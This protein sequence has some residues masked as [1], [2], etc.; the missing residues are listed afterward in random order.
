MI[1]LI[2]LMRILYIFHK[3]NILGD[4]KSLGLLG[5]VSS[6]INFYKSKKHSTGYRLALALEELGPIFI[7]IGQTLSIR[8]DIIGKEIADELVKLQNNLKSSDFSLIKK[9]IEAEFQDSLENIFTDF[10]Q[11][12]V[13]AASIA[14]VHKAVINDKIVAVKILRPDIEK[15]FLKDIK[16]MYF[17]AR[18]MEY[19]ISNSSRLKATDI[20]KNFHQNILIELDLTLEAAAANTIQDY[21]KDDDTIIVPEIYWEYT[22]K[23][24]L[25]M[26]WVDGTSIYNEQELALLEIDNIEVATNLA[27]MFFLQAFNHGFYHA[28]L[29]PG[30]ILISNT[31]K[32]I[33]LDFGIMGRLEQSLRISMAEIIYGFLKKDYDL[34]AEIYFREGFVPRTKSK[35]L[36]SQSL[37]AI[38]EP[39]VGKPVSE[40]SI[41]RLIGKLLEMSQRFEMVTK[42]ELFALQKT[43]TLIEGI[44][45]KLDPKINMWQLARPW[46]NEWAIKNI[47]I[48]GKMKNLFQNILKKISNNLQDLN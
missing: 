13:A 5:K 33:L 34:V 21:H 44:G 1:N 32:I 40:I 30:N 29:H 43:M 24:I 36:L 42:P 41:A 2:R 39:I 23:N 11:Q 27:K 7:K 25:T 46:I 3:F 28:D 14:Q 48:E 31:G 15:K 45:Y 47:G 10:E 4:F 26:Q 17:I 37:R 16:L 9:I 12:P 8:P 22:T 18:V 6:V 35:I 20:V 19:F 38:A